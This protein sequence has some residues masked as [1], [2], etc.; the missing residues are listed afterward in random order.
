MQIKFDFLSTYCKLHFC[1]CT[2]ILPWQINLDPKFPYT[3]NFCL[4]CIFCDTSNLYLIITWSAFTR[5]TK[6]LSVSWNASCKTWK[7]QTETNLVDQWKLPL[8]PRNWNTLNASHLD[9][10]GTSPGDLQALVS[11]SHN[12]IVLWTP[13][14]LRTMC[15]NRSFSECHK[16]SLGYS[17][18]LN[19]STALIRT[20][21]SSSVE[22]GYILSALPHSTI[23]GRGTRNP[24]IL[25]TDDP[26][27][28]NINTAQRTRLVGLLPSDEQAYKITTNRS[29]NLQI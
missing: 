10:E 25:T 4:Q 17:I 23:N 3:C 27:K 15:Q 28:C 20:Q 18:D 11:E 24:P 22:N 16:A 12:G 8:I 21:A 9:L 29:D 6:N 1:K 2:S 26:I 13:H 7:M 19:P 14:R 5:V